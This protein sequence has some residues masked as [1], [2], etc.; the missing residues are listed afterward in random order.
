MA[1]MNAVAKKAT[2]KCHLCKWIEREGSLP[3]KECYCDCMQSVIEDIDW[4]DWKDELE[5]DNGLCPEFQED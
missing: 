1:D 5:E 4:D 2:E 3:A